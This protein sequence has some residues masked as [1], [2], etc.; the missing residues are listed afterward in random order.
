VADKQVRINRQGAPYLQLSLRDKTGAIEARLWNAGE[1]VAR[2]FDAGDY[3][4]ARGKVQSFQGANQLIL[5]G[6]ELVAPDQVD[7]AEFRPAGV[8]D[9]DKLVKRLKELLLGIRNHHLRALVECFLIDD[10]F[11][12]KFSAAPAGI[13]NHHAYNGGLL[14]HVVT[15]LTLVDRTVDL[16]PEVD[17]DLLLAGAFLHDVGKIDELSYEHNFGY[18][19]AG[20]LVGHLVIGVGILHEKIARSVELLGEPFPHELRLRLEHMIV[21]HH[22]SHEFGSPKLPMT[23][24]AIALHYLDNL[25]AKLHAVAREMRD[26]T[27]IAAGWT[28]F[29]PALNRRLFKGNSEAN[30][31]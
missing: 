18:T 24:E 5:T 30:G 9:V 20:Q 25:D 16:Y 17:R 19:D 22:G 10:A 13:R 4:Q 27:A 11:I 12:R 23:L 31:S 6:F 3:L 15:L 14:E 21:S 8:S 1:D 2:R 26:E 29:N 7:P 28:P